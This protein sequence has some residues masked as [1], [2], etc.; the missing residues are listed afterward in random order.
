MKWEYA[1]N[2]VRHPPDLG[3]K[4]KLHDELVQVPS[5]RMPCVGGAPA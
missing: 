1:Q 4:R 5:A 3:S 2:A